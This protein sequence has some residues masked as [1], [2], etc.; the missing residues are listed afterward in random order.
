MMKKYYQI[1]E[2]IRWKTSGLISSIQ[3]VPV[4]YYIEAKDAA[5]NAVPFS[6]IY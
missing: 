5:G 4:K 1:P 2:L 6:I 3:T